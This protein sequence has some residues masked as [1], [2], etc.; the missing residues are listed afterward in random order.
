M[1]PLMSDAAY[2]VLLRKAARHREAGRL[3]EAIAAY[4]QLLSRWP[5]SPTVWYNL[6]WLLRRA[7]HFGEALDAYAEALHRGGERPEE[8]RLNRALILAHDLH[9][10][11]DA[12]R[13]L[14]AALGLSP[15]YIPALMNLGNLNEDLGRRDAAAHFYERILELDP[16]QYSILAR[17]ACL[18][19]FSD[20]ADPLIARLRRAVGDCAAGSGERAA[21][22]FALGQALD[23]C[24][25]YDA[26]FEAY[27]LANRLS[28]E[29]AGPG[30]RPYDRAAQERLVDRIIAAFSV[31]TPA[32]AAA[33]S[34]P[35]PVFVLGMFRSGSTLL[36]QLLAG[37]PAVTPGGELELL[38]RIA[39][40]VLARYPEGAASAP[41]QQIEAAASGYR[42][43][44]RAVFPH[45]DLITDKRP[46]NFMYI[47]LIKRLFP[48]AKI[49]HTVRDPL[50]NCLSVFFLH[51]DQRMS[52]A[53]DLMDIAHY[54]SQYRRLMAH[55]RQLF[56]ADIHDVSYDALVRDPRPPMEKLTA[57]LELEWSE[58][59]LRTCASEH[60][61]RTASVWQVREPLYRSSSGRAQHY[62][63]HVEKIRQY[64][65]VGAPEGIAD[66]P[67]P[68]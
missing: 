17:Y 16:G 39:E 60:A 5:Q 63:A 61:V 50:D 57:F 27:A 1:P 40:Q 37:H 8:I 25:E 67:R 7:G 3:G 21:A 10:Y 51:L 47:G 53:L 15:A 34:A 49:V 62:R 32:P 22:A 42:R 44:L 24:R 58:R 20:P 28:R 2:Q 30:F 48:R 64:L 55:W 12:E 6:A 43:S 45:A 4:R 23:A 41:A 31:P 46:D 11:T 35:H 65:A 26:A 68:A 9:R 52:Y 14:E 19:K 38:P 13:E 66:E 36:E 33:D 59:C 18:R 56:A 54:Y 29:S